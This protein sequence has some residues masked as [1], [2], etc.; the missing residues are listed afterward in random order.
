MKKIGHN[1]SSIPLA[2]H[3]QPRF[4]ISFLHPKYIAVWLLMAILFICIWLPRRWALGIG[5]GIG[6][7][8]SKVN[9]KRY[10][11]AKV[12]ITMAFPN[13]SA[14]EV[15][16]LCAASFKSYG[17]NIIDMGYVWWAPVWMLNRNVEI[18]GLEHLEAIKADNKS[19]ILFTH[20]ATGMDQCGTLLSSIYPSISMMKKLKN[21]LLD[22]AITSGRTRFNA[23]LLLREMG[24]RKLVRA[25]R[26]GLDCYYIPDEDLGEAQSIF[27]PFFNV[28]TATIPMLGRMAKLSNAVAIPG[29]VEL[30]SS[31]K[32]IVR[33][34]P[35]LQ[36]FPTGDEY[37]DALKMNQ[38]IE[39]L[40]M[41][42]PE[43]YMWTL[44][45]FKT[46]P[47][48]EKPPYIR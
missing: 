44:K 2:E 43:Q 28:P 35:P 17:Q 34:L 47:N 22:W 37:Q 12:N 10:D 9:K 33:L 7:I 41:I 26:L 6:F 23:K 39:Q 48:G 14:T 27:V 3:H 29:M 19:F 32:H 5:S 25:M 42:K 4:H 20:H 30:S 11:I 38:A 13:K 36:N 31:G 8:L 16:Q 24:I 21:P 1:G 40:V 45:M 15:E 18:H 46:R